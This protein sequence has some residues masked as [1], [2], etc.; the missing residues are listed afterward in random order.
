[1]HRV[2]L[3]TEGTRY[4]GIEAH[5]LNL[6][7]AM[8][9]LGGVEYHL[10]LFDRGPLTQQAR[11]LRVPVHLLLREDK[12]DTRVIAQL[13]AIIAKSG[14]DFVHA[15]GYLADIIAGWACGKSRTPLMT[16]VHG[17]PEKFRGLAALKMRLNLRLDRR[18]IRR[19]SAH[20]I[21]V[22]DFLKDQLV[23]RRIAADKITVVPN[24][25]FDRPPDLQRRHADRM[26]LELPPD[27]PT[28]G[29]AARLEPVKDPL[30]FIEFARLVHAQLPNARFLVA[31]E[32][33]LRQPMYD[34]ALALNL[35]PAFR[36]LGHLHD[37]D[38]FFSAADVFVLT[39]RSEGVPQVALEAM[40]AKRPVLAPAVGGLPEVLAGL[41]E[42]TAPPRDLTKLAELAVK[43]L[44]DPAR[45]AAV[46]EAAR[47]RFLAAYTADRMARETKLIYDR[48]H[49]EGA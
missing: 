46:G 26:A 49:P 27:A 24:G 15:H 6:I 11:E 41:G 40:R 31:G 37:L 28:V 12:Y 2:L 39:S 17:A 44:R 32:G 22:A 47:A 21:A 9:Q 42:L 18:A 23:R 29:F 34:R 5:L 16:T 3:A 8:Q 10:A 7:A 13:R 48:V 36:F 1:M 4:A 45:L 20:V 25:V 43:L 35:L 14:A 19:R 33:A 38:A 30:A